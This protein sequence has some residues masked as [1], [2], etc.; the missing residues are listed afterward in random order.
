[1]VD[2]A[3]PDWAARALANTHLLDA[4]PVSALRELGSACRQVTLEP[5]AVL[6]RQGETGECLYFVLHGRLTVTARR[7]DGSDGLLGEVWEGEFVGE[8]AL[9]GSP[10]HM[11]TVTSATPVTLVELSRDALEDFLGQHGDIRDSFRQTLDHRLR[12]A[13]T[14]RLRP[15]HDELAATLMDV[16]GDLDPPVVASLEHELRWET[17]PRGA[18]LMRQGE[19]GDC[20]YLVVSGRL[21]VFG[22][23]N[24]GSVV[25][26]AE[27]G[28]GEAIGEMALLSN[29]Q[30]LASVDALRDTELL[31]LSRAGFERLVD[32]QPKALAF[33]TRI[34]VARLSRSVRSRAPIAQLGARQT[35]T[36]ADCE[37]VV[38]TKDLVL[39][40]LKITQMYH[41]LSQELALLV[42]HA[43]ANW[44]TFACSASKTAGYSIR[45]EVVRPLAWLSTRRRSRWVTEVRDE[46]GASAGRDI[47][48][49]RLEHIQEIVSAS[50]SAGNLKVFAELAPVFAEMIRTFHRDEHHDRD[51][52]ARFLAALDRGPTEAGGQDTLAEALAH[53]YEAMFERN[54]KS[55]AELVLLGNIKVGLHE[56]MRLQPNILEALNAPVAVGLRDPLGLRLAGRVLP[57]LPRAVPSSVKSRNS[58]IERRL[59]DSTANRWRR[60]VTRYVMT[61]RL[62][63]GELR[64]GAQVPELAPATKFPDVLQTLEHPELARVVA[65]YDGNGVGKSPR[66]ADWGVLEDRMRFIVSLFRSRQRSLELFSQPFLYEQLL[67]IAA[68]RVPF[69]KL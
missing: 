5:G 59:V 14:R 68:E 3:D 63:Y 33:F 41:R 56:Q 1:M 31:A 65:R 12:W 8:G 52:L 62:P 28:P 50:V 37:D 60:F 38:R 4:L 20:L 43:D 7:P 44:C 61:L 36:L 35:V 25:E 27:V 58:A 19:E 45:G 10:S 42:G 34:I 2:E 13:R 40:N 53:Y 39:R 69:G 64:L 29:E 32:A 18:I 54:P 49:A 47:V 24:D 23:R 57:L 66:A 22:E 21:R 30:R 55:K 9:L 51:K 17:L 6:M 46:P 67:D 48:A 15:A 26:I 11:A 16:V